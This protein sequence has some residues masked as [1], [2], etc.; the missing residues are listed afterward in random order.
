[1]SARDNLGAAVPAAGPTGAG[2]R[3]EI[4]ARVRSALADRPAPPPAPRAYRTAGSGTPNLPP[5]ATPAAVLDL[6]TDR[7]VDYRAL[8]RRAP[9][10]GGASA[11]GQPANGTDAGD[12][13]IAS[14][15]A[16]A[17]AD[18]G[19]RRIVRPPGLPATWLARASGVEFLDDTPPLTAAALDA[20]DGVIT[21]C[22]V[23]IAETGTIILDAG[24]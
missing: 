13:A 2:A 1:M 19:A 17:L 8:V 14:A 16:A 7:L 6:L 15:V 11:E 4:L 21:G 10:T 20:A 3:A 18:R 9:H 24:P 12:A 23:A 22:A 5:D